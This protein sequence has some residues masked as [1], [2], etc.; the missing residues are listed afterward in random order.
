MFSHRPLQ[1]NDLDAICSLPQNEEE[2]YFMFPKAVYPLTP[3]QI[4]EAV[5]N[6]LEPT[7][8]LCDH[9][10]VSYANFYDNDCESCWLGNVIVSSD[11]R[12][13][14]VSQF[15]I[16]TM[17]SIAKQN[18]KVKKLKLVCHNTNTRGIL[19]YKKYGF[20]PFDISVRVKPSGEFIAGIHMEK[21]L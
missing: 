4:V 17:E 19:F 12:G 15:L 16:D 13:K 10:V 7:V 21:K 14:G 20:K 18:L 2:L 6:R 1:E 5:K 3:E 8:I 9:I 11:Y